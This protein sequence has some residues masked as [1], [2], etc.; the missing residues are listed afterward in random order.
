LNE[1]FDSTDAEPSGPVQEP[2]DREPIDQEALE[3]DDSLSPIRTRHREET[4]R[5]RDAPIALAVGIGSFAGV[6]ALWSFGPVPEVLLAR[7]DLGF[8]L[9]NVL[10]A[11]TVLI[12]ARRRGLRIGQLFVVG[13]WYVEVFWG[14]AAFVGIWIGFEFAAWLGFEPADPLGQEL[15]RAD[16]LTRWEFLF[17]AALFAP[18]A[19]ELLFRGVVQS[20]LY[21][22]AGAFMACLFQAMLFGSVHWRGWEVIVATGAFRLCVGALALWRGSLLA[23]IVAH[24]IWNGAV[25]TWFIVAYHLSQHVPAASMDEARTPPLWISEQTTF[26]I[27]LEGSARAQYWAARERYGEEGSL[28]PKDE[29]KAMRLVRKRFPSDEEFGAWAMLRIEEIY[30]Q[31]LDDPRRAV[32]TGEEILRLYPDRKETQAAAIGLMV[33]AYVELEDEEQV[34]RLLKRLEDEFSE[35]E[36][37]PEH[38]AQLRVWAEEVLAAD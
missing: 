25:G 20:S 28:L 26:G 13:R 14:I 12:L 19:E 27:E 10:V 33:G 4:F 31:E 11:A 23:P 3:P 15:A 6:W 1:R 21:P 38:A 30:L 5:L 7:F 37:V 32:T 29:L 8:A 17:V 34:E 24:G 22:R 36:G 9:A 18:L 2:V 35:V 16:L